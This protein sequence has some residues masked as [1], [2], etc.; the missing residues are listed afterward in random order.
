MVHEHHADEDDEDAQAL[1]GEHSQA[2]GAVLTGHA[3]RVVLTVG[4][5]LLA[6]QAVAGR[7]LVSTRTSARRFPL[8]PRLC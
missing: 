7:P 6:G 2:Q 4:A 5:A 8:R 1:E 3:G